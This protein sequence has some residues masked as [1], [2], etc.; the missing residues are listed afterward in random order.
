MKQFLIKNNANLYE[1]YCKLSFDSL[2]K[3]AILIINNLQASE[4]KSVKN[5]NGE[6]VNVDDARKRTIQHWQE[7]WNTETS[8]RGTAKR[9]PNITGWM[10]RKFGEVNYYLTQLL[11]GHDYFCK[12]LLRIRKMT[13][14]MASMVMRQ[15]LMR[16][17]LSFIVRDRDWKEGI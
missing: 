8:G 6:I 11:S 10:E 7:K 9:L 5:V 12:Y 2:R 4:R 1:F 3:S 17:T 16:N 14:Q 13:Q 15:L